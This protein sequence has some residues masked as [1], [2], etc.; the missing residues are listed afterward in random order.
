M[1]ICTFQLTDTMGWNQRRYSVL[2]SVIGLRA[3]TVWNQIRVCRLSTGTAMLKF[4]SVFLEGVLVSSN[5]NSWQ[6]SPESIV[7]V[8]ITMPKNEK[9]T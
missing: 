8:L 9:G 2:L 5:H 6:T 4:Q 1:F 3:A 7:T